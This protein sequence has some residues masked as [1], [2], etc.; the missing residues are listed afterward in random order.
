[1]TNEVDQYLDALFDRLAG[2]GA[3]GRRALAEAEDHLRTAVEHEMARGATEADAARD[4][5]ARFGALDKVAGA[6]RR[7]HRRSRFPAIVSDAW[8]LIGLVPLGL[9]LGFGST[10]AEQW[11]LAMRDCRSG[12]LC[13]IESVT[14]DLSIG[15]AVLVLL[16]TLVLVPRIVARRRLRLPASTRGL[17]TV[18]AFAFTTLAVLLVGSGPYPWWFGTLVRGV[19][20]GPGIYPTYMQAGAFAVCALASVAWA[21]VRRR[22]NAF[23]PADPEPAAAA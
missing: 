2:T 12:G 23:T 22:R 8:L 15:A 18:A 17:P 9:A 21:M 7:E 16:A 1:M 4:A 19:Y 13:V 14:R 11:L 3:A 5:V 20:A 6:L 10:A